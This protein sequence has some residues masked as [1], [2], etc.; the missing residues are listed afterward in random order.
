MLALPCLCV[1]N[2][3]LEGL[4][5]AVHAVVAL[6]LCAFHA[7]CI[8]LHVLALLQPQTLQTGDA[9]Q[10]LSAHASFA[11]RNK[12]ITPQFASEVRFDD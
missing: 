9:Q 1:R 2:C 11:V 7:A 6:P 5:D 10:M 12:A 4:V 3:V 8:N